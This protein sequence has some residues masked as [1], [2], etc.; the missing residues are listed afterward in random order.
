[1]S[2][3]SIKRPLVAFHQNGSEF[4]SKWITEVYKQKDKS[5]S[6]DLWDKLANFVIDKM[7]G[8]VIVLGGSEER[9]KPQL[10]Q[11]DGLINLVGQTDVNQFL[12]VIEDC[13]LL[14]GVDSA[15][16]SA[17]LAINKPTIVFVRTYPD[18][19]RDRMFLT[20]YEDTV[21]CNIIRS[22]DENTILKLTKKYIAN[23]VENSVI[24]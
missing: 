4:S 23:Y 15:A 13:D 14:I 19:T 10:E 11:R 18:P 5:Y 17:S 22:E 3:D 1:M 21:N 12:T 16:K 8:S 7:D 20:P 2:Y 6:I 24:L 9:Q